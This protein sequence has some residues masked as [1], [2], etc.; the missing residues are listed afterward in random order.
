MKTILLA[1]ALALTARTGWAA[2]PPAPTPADDKLALEF[3]RTM[4]A[5]DRAL[6]YE[7]PDDPTLEQKAHADALTKV[8]VEAGQDTRL[9]RWVYGRL[10]MD[11]QEAESW[12]RDTHPDAARA[13][14]LKKRIEYLDR[15]KYLIDAPL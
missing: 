4:L 11:R 10:Q 2:D 9:S 6:A 8:I 14:Q 15:V 5:V 12:L 7:R 3:G 13:R 1:V